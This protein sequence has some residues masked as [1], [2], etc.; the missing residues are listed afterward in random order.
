MKNIK[1][2]IKF[3]I[4]LTFWLSV[5]YGQDVNKFDENGKRHGLW[6]GIYEDSKRPR[7]EGTFDHGKEI[8]IF[9]YFDNTTKLVVIATRDFSA[10]DGSHYTTF[11][12]QKGFKVSEGKVVGK[13][14]YEGL[15][16]YYHLDSPKIMAL[17]NYSNGKLHGVKKVFYNTEKIAEETNYVNGVKQ[18]A[19]KKYAENGV[20]LEDSNFKDGEYEGKATF[21][22]A[23]KKITGQGVFKN[24]KKVGMWKILEDGKL[25]TV[26]MNLQGKKFEKRTKPVENYG[27]N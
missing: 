2:K 27:G 20:V 19:Y 16:K 4:L 14:T 25:K 5:G 13:D 11:Y 18:G 10:N 15:W 17:E 12:N 3:M 26:N 24:G 6:K 23:E 22:T 7:Y 1:Q 21:Q 9:K 8:G